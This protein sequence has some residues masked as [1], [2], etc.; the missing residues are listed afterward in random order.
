VETPTLKVTALVLTLNEVGSIEEVL[1]EIPKDLVHEILVVD[2]ASTDGTPELVRKLG[3]Q[4]ITQERRGYGDAITTGVKAATGDVILLVAG[5]GSYDMEDVPRLL[6]AI[7]QGHDIAWASRYLPGGGSTDDTIITY[8]GNRFLTFLVNLIHGIG[9]S[10]AL[11]FYFAA[12][13]SVFQSLD[14]KSLGFEYCAEFSIKAHRKGYKFHQIPSKEKS[15]RAGKK[16]V[17]N[18]PDGFRIM[19]KILTA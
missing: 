14:L 11:Y 16:K 18:I 8:I 12:R 17:K 5:D 3:Y 13:K 6:E 2:G 19:W 9:L 15:R 7:E 1:S 4:V 10:D